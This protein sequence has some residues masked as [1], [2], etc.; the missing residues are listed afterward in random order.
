[1][2]TLHISILIA[3][4][5]AG[6]ARGEYE[7]PVEPIQEGYG[8]DGIYSVSLVA[9]ANPQW[10]DLT[11]SVYFPD[12][13]SEPAPAIF[14]SHAWGLNDPYIYEDLI[15]HA[16]S[17]GYVL[18]FSPYKT[19]S[20]TYEER[21][22]MLFS[23]FQAAVSGYPEIL[24]SALCGFVGHSFGGGATP[25]MARRGLVE[26]GWGSEGSFM[27]VMAPWY[28][29]DMSQSELEGFPQDTK[30]LVQLYSE[31]EANDHRMAIDLFENIG[32]P[33]E[34]KDCV[35]VYPDLVEE[36]PYLADHPLPSQNSPNPSSV[37]NAYDSYGV[38]R[39]FDALA[40]YAFTGNPAAA[41]IALGNGSAE[42]L[43]MGAQLRPLTASDDPLAARPCSDFLY[44]CDSPE[45]PRSGYC[46]SCEA[47]VG[48]GDLPADLSDAG[49]KAI[50]PNPFRGSTKLKFSLSNRGEVEVTIH[51]VAGRLVAV[52][53]G[54]TFDQGESYLIWDGLGRSGR[55][56]SSGVYLARMTVDDVFLG[57]EKLVLMR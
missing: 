11:V 8:A 47:Q 28:V 2:R 38:F 29:M 50:V 30:L 44:P 53:P 51:D 14:F 21:Y 12:G 23:G 6:A 55:Q 16:V 39:L 25:S 45:N 22:D 26:S 3:L 48:V 35:F 31:D 5:L 37:F 17:R 49:I 27:L 41:I 13:P 56:L 34:N 36:Y 15:E 10:P 42:Q 20:A 19:V 1:M 52:L 43:D 4:S 57:Q 32:I 9:F 40:D 18:V 24:D 54:R 33:D 7:G 46:G